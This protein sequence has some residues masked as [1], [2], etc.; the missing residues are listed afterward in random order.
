[1]SVGNDYQLC[2]E[3]VHGAPTLKQTVE[4]FKDVAD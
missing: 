4:Q 1:M 2:W 3:A